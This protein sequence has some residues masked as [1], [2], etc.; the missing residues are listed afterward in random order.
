MLLFYNISIE[1]VIFKEQKLKI[2]I[3]QAAISM[4]QAKNK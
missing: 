4:N 1:F 3:N 2:Y